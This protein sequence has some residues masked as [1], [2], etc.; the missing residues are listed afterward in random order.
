MAIHD[1]NELWDEV[2]NTRVGM[3]TTRDREGR[4]NS[5]PMTSLETDIDGV[6]WFF[7]S[8][9]SHI[10]VD[11]G[12]D[13][14]AN[15]SFTRPSESF[16][17]SLSGEAELIADRRQYEKLWN[18]VYRAW[19]SRGLD[20]PQLVLIRFTVDNAEYWDS[21]NNRMVQILQMLR[22]AVTHEKPVNLGTHGNFS[23]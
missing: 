17:V 14:R 7:T 12:G 10:A 11:I 6:L 19:F 18:P 20:D 13:A 15:I 2:R 16:Y 23:L 9:D 5:R 3:F 4:L 8:L 21:D 1:L 22:A